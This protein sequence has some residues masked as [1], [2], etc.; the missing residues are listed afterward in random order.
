MNNSNWTGR[1]SR[2]SREAFGHTVELDE[3]H[4][5]DRWVGIV[6]AFVA[7]FLLALVLMGGA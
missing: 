7:G 5:G 2:T 4:T 6:A 3:Q 1:M